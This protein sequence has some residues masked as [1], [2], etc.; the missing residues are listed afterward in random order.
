MT[1]SDAERSFLVAVPVR[2]YEFWRVT[3]GSDAD[4]RRMVAEFDGRAQRVSFQ[5]SHRGQ[6]TSY[7]VREET[8]PDINT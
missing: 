1:A 2:G 6:P 8:V 7:Q 5:T 4:A 3:A